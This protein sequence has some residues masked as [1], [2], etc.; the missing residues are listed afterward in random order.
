DLPMLI[1]AP[2]R[3][4]FDAGASADGSIDPLPLA[5][6]YDNLANRLLPHLTVRMQRPRF[7]TAI[8]VGAL[9]CDGL[10]DEISADGRTPSWLVFE[11]HIIEALM[12]GQQDQQGNDIW[13]I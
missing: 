10:H 7:L 13:G 2:C 8:A 1:A 6:T 3:R 9:I 5:S 12:R 11:W 4:P